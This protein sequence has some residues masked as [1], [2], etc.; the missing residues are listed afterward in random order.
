MRV[1]GREIISVDPDAYVIDALFFMK[2]NNIR[3]IVVSRSNNILGIFSVDEALYHIINNDVESKLKDAKLKFPVIVKS[4]ELK[5]ITRSMIINDTD[6]V[7]Y[8]NKI[9]TYKDVISQIDWSKSN[10]LIGELSKE[11]IFVEPYT[12]IK[13][14][15]EL[16]LK[17]KIRH[18]P[19]YDKFLYGIVSSR[20]IVYN[21]DIDLNL[22]I[23]KIM[24]VEVY[25]VS[26]EESL[27]TVVSTMIKRNIGSVIVTDS[28]NIEIVTLKDL[29]AFALSNLIY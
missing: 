7:I 24:I 22:S 19:V 16:M 3:R 20:D 8:D 4:N 13:T 26:K 11:A 2:R 23:S 9:I 12:K 18:M 28:K 10:A 5:E 15:G 1:E 27:H 6:S 17:N 21:Y 29:V 14:V 25:S